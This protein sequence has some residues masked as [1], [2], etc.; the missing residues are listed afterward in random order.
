M[1]KNDR[2]LFARLREAGV[3]KKVAKTISEISEDAS[4]KTVRAARGTVAQL[5]T[6]ADEIERRLPRETP[7]AR[8]PARSARRGTSRS[9]TRTRRA[10]T[11]TRR[12]AS[13]SSA[14]RA[15]TSATA[16]SSRSRST[17]RARTNDARAPR[18]QNKAKILASLKTGPKTASEVAK[19]TGIGTGTVGSTLTKMA[20]AGEVVKAERGY[21][22]PK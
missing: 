22:L 9:A 16:R 19:E 8:A 3:R 11:S 6:L 4:N 10:S 15:S 2:D 7:A 13:T 20:T 12:R 5:R 21:G 18:G 1:A 17:G 14:R